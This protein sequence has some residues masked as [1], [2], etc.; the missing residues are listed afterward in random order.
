MKSSGTTFALAATMSLLLMPVVGFSN[1]RTAARALDAT[2]LTLIHQNLAVAPDA[3]ISIQ[4]HPPTSM[5]NG[6]VTVRVYPP[7]TLREDLKKSIVGD[8]SG[9]NDQV[10]IDPATIVADADGNLTVSVPTESTENTGPALRLAHA[11][12]Y[13][14]V[15]RATSASGESIGQLVTFVYRLP[16]ADEP[17]L[18]Q[19]S[20]AVLASITAPPAVSPDTQ[21]LPDQTSAELT[22]LLAYS[23][24]I[25]VSLAISPEILAR[26]DDATRTAL[27]TVMAN[28]RTLSQP[29][30]PFDPSSASA[31]GLD[32]QFRNLLVA[33]EDATS[34]AGLPQSDRAAW[35][36]PDSITDAGAL[37]L[38]SGGARLL[39][40]PSDTYLA[41]GGN[42]GD[43]TDYSQLF[44]TV[45]AGGG[46]SQNDE[47]CETQSMTCMPTA[48]IDPLISSRFTDASLSDE[49]AALYTAADVV[50]YREQ[51]SDSL[52]PSNRH[53]L[54]LGLDGAGIANAARMKRSIEM[55]GPTGA[56]KFIT[57]DE[58][59][60]NSSA[61]I[62]DGRQIEL[63]LPQPEAQDL[64]I[65]TKALSDV[66][67]AVTT[68]ASMLVDDGGRFNGWIG[69]V[70]RLYST[71][72]TDDQAT[73][74]IGAINTSLTAIRK[75]VVA[76]DAYSF[77][78]TGTST[79]LPIRITN[80]CGEP[81]HVVVRL[82]A[83]ANK[84][85]FAQDDKPITL[86]PTTV[87]PV[88]IPVTARTNG[89][90]DVTLDV[91]TPTGLYNVTDSVRLHASINALTGLPQV[92]TGAGLL[93]LMTW[94]VRNLRRSRRQRR[95]I[96]GRTEHPAARAE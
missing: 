25:K 59:D 63:N 84:L 1:G 21:A 20:V 46:D 81:L 75:C 40:V 65:R 60:Q 64:H 29:L 9:F 92:I 61:L 89:S 74:A 28:G 34:A 49:Q 67:L 16:A 13:P 66:R 82:T 77:T 31:S 86:A 36:A 62:N 18:G 35:F 96:G 42:L 39:V 11:G 7:I 24:N 10:A 78:L 12:L 33:G 8:L 88:Q 32:D 91:L 15:V 55:L 53:A 3:P 38:R 23:P 47:T 95:I 43:I 93:I 70:D 54:V 69:T 26:L 73:A 27:Q 45:I 37:L 72:I 14:V 6:A 58:F 94:W 52:S 68:V 79:N 5:V 76:P 87:T 17:P 57:L 51:F 41:A 22:E 48:V 2:P 50:I 30:V 80:R 19:L 4:F 71:A 56:A 90:F 85:D 44:K 83:A